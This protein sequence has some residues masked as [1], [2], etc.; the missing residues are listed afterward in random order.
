MKNKDPD[1]FPEDWRSVRWGEPSRSYLR[2]SIALLV[3]TCAGFAYVVWKIAQG[4]MP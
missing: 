4:M 2:V 3:I 1:K